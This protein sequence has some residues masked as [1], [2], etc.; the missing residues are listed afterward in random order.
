MDLACMPAGLIREDESAC[1]REQEG[2]P[3]NQHA[4][5]LFPHTSI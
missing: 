4:P 5:P 3:K 1:D 2:E